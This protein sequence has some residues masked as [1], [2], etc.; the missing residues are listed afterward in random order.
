LNA[1]HLL[2]TVRGLAATLGAAGLA[3]DA[4]VAER[5]LADAPS[6]QIAQS[7][8]SVQAA[9]A[10]ACAAIAA[11]Q[12]M[13]RRL[14]DAMSAA[15]GPA[16]AHRVEATEGDRRALRAGLLALAAQL[17]AADMA[18]T[19]AMPR[20]LD[21]YEAVDAER[22]SALAE[23]VDTLDFG[24]AAILCRAFIDALPAGPIDAVT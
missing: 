7:T 6:L 9:M 19:V 21:R 11:A 16:R 15:A 5:V 2:H 12:P 8:Q 10:R 1:S 17:D 22:L 4:A 20:L 18:A 24:R 13:L 23:S 3:L 14:F